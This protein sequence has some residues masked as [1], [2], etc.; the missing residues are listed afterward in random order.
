[1]DEPLSA[2]PEA[3]RIV[4]RFRRLV[5]ALTS[6]PVC[7][8][9]R[10][11]HFLR[12]LSLAVGTIAAHFGASENDFETEGRFHLFAKLFERRPEEFLNLATAHADDVGVFAFEARL[13]VVLVAAVVH[14]I[15]LVDQP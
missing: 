9:R 14:E 10:S 4:L 6:A 5:L 7:A 2:P 15:E 3:I 8:V 1:M 13:I 12:T 11:G